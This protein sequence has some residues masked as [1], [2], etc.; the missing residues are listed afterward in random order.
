MI[1]NYNCWNN[2]SIIIGMKPLHLLELEVESFTV[3]FYLDG[4]MINGFN[5]V[6]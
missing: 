6:P 2:K 1:H 3:S 4:G 5:T